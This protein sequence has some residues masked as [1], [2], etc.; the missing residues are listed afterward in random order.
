MS[1][2]M[3]ADVVGY[4]HLIEVDEEATI[5][6]VKALR[7]ELIEPLVAAINGRIVKLMGDGVLSNSA[8]WST[9]SPALSPSRRSLPSRSGRVPARLLV[10]RIGINLGD[11]VVDG[12]DVLGDVVNVASR[13]QQLCK[14]GGVLIS[15]TAYDHMQGRL[16]LPLDFVGEEHVK[17]IERPVRSYAVRFGE[18]P[19]REGRRG[20][21]RSDI[22]S[23]A[24]AMVS[25]P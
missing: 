6:A 24:A 15:G 9:R 11:I 3:V 2:I 5:A 12:D 1:A 10:L 14:P 19:R 17:N 20:R 23:D 25:Q 22:F 18:T 16:G 4:S 7:V 13:L 21:S 8:R